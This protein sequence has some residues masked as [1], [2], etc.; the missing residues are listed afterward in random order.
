MSE[1]P[2]QEINKTPWHLWTVGIVGLLW[3][4]KR[5]GSDG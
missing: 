5:H 3:I 2:A 1:I 4:I